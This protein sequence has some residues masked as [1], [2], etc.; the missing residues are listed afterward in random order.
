MNDDL[1]FSIG[2]LFEENNDNNNKNKT[3][4]DDEKEIEKMFKDPENV[5]DLEN[6][7]L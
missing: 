3:T 4:A 5:R 7:E 1:Y 2:D 6:D